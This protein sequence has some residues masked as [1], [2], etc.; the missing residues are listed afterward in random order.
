MMTLRSASLWL[1]VALLAAC[2]SP[3]QRNVDQA[4][5]LLAQGRSEEGLLLLEQSAKSDP[6]NGEYRRNWL[7]QRD[8]VLDRLLREAEMLRS[9]QR[10]S[11]AQDRLET[12]LRIQ[13]GMARAQDML[14]QLDRDISHAELIEQAMT[15]RRSGQP[16]QAR[17]LLKQVLTEAPR[18]VR[19]RKL[20]AELDTSRNRAELSPLSADSPLLL[21]V[22]V[23]FRN[24]P[25]MSIFDMLSQS[26]G[27]NFVFD[28]EVK[29]DGQATILARDTP[30]GD[31]L[32]VLLGSQ[33]L[34]RRIL[35]DK[36]V[37]IYPATPARQKDF[38]SLNVK[39]FYLSN[40]EAKA[41]ASLIKT[42][43]KSRDIYT[44]DKLN[45]LVMRDTP[46][47]I[48]VAEK[49]VA[50]HDLA[51]PE[52][53]LEV[54]VMEIGSEKL[55]QLGVQ[56][57]DQ[58][59]VSLPKSFDGSSLSIGELR[60]L[61]RDGLKL[62]TGDPAL[63]LNLRR[64]DGTSETLANPRIRVKNRE[65]AK[66]HIGDRVPVITTTTN[67]TSGSVA[68]SVSYLDVGLKLDVEPQVYQD[69]EV[70][71]RLNLEVSNIVKEVPS[72]SGLLT[73]QIGTRTTS[74]ALRLRD[75]E[76]Q[77]LAGLI[78]Q[79][80][81]ESASR[82]PGLGQ[83]PMLGK[84]FSSEKHQRSKSELVLLITPRILRSL[85]LPDA[86]Q[87]EFQ[88]GTEDNVGSDQLKLPK[89]TSQVR[90]PPADAPA[91]LQIEPPPPPSSPPIASVAR[92]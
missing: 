24:V 30:L 67:P 32:N 73:Y 41:A 79:E 91:Q 38:E 84:L 55:A 60:G 47:A 7:R 20:M 86:S 85:A 57:P 61:G 13:P 90:V 22:T 3:G 88:S 52:V 92:P 16:E 76:T 54:E 44:D 11:E 35:N 49:L 1:S 34:A 83:L 63:A 56:F 31:A 17:A 26:T 75:G 2:A 6:S 51:E 78:K 80:E 36:S 39:T 37:L 25:L 10:Y 33:H 8:A 59:S 40:I 19:A 46:E 15:A 62:N 18:H 45:L 68:E 42:I 64:T 9:N 74:T 71:I 77:V 82:L 27:V 72:K 21:P 65:K 48:A 23:E 69:D 53:M 66:I 58:V 29:L 28:R 12:M 87:T 4:Q 89:Q 14:K 5:Q 81:I 70:G 50:A 43:V